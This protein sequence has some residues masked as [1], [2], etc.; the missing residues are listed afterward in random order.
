VTAIEQ[1]AIGQQALGAGRW[2]LSHGI[3]GFEIF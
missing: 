2:A 3:H 1:Q